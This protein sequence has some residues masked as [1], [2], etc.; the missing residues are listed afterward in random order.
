MKQNVVQRGLFRFFKYEINTNKPK[1]TK[2]YLQKVLKNSG[3]IDLKKCSF[4]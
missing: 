1:E 4:Q 3:I 2:S